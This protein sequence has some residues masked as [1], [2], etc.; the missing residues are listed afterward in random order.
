MYCSLNSFRSKK[1]LK[2]FKKMNN[3]ANIKFKSNVSAPIKH[4]TLLSSFRIHLHDRLP[5]NNIF[6]A[7]KGNDVQKP[8]LLSNLTLV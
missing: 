3:I 8:K 4:L 2:P 7:K 1:A 5:R 6:I